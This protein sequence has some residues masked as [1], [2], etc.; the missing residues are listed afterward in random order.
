MNKLKFLRF[1][2]GL[3]SYPAWYFG[4]LADDIDT[5][6]HERIRAAKK[7]IDERKIFPKCNC[8]RCTGIKVDSYYDED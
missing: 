2:E 7:A 1:M 4:N 5:D 6:L 3:F 8:E